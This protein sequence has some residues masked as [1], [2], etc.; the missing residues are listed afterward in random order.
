VRITSDELADLPLAAAWC[1]E[2]GAMV[3][4][5]PEW[6]GAGVDTVQYRLGALRL[7]V[8]TDGHS[9][10]VAALCARVLDELDTTARSAP[11]EAELMRR[12]LRAGLHLVMGRPDLTERSAVEVLAAVRAAAGEENVEVV[13]GSA[14]SSAV[15]GGD[16]VA[17]ALKQLATNAGK[18]DAA[19]DL[20][21]EESGPG[22]FRLRWRGTVA[23]GSVRTSRHPDRRGRWG[24]GLVR[25]AADALGATVVPVRYGENGHSEATFT[26]LSGAARFTLPLAAVDQR[27][28]IERAT[29]AWD[30]ETGLLPG[31]PVSA[32]LAELV[33]RAESNGSGMVTN[34]AFTARRGIANTWISLKP[35]STRDQA[36]DLIAGVAHENALLGNGAHALRVEGC[37]QVLGLILGA[38]T[39][40]WLRPALDEH[41]AA[42]CAAF[43]APA[44]TLRGI[45]RDAPPAPMAAFLASE[46]GGGELA[47]SNRRWTYRPARWSPL[48]LRLATGSA[49]T[50][51]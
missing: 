37:V 18:H 42:A 29:R 27:R 2:D 22:I 23:S 39:E 44:P 4:S 31:Q 45:G 17:L 7:I 24:L 41:L 36:R 46:G 9:A 19:T 32:D 28:R 20:T 38:S 25:L 43:G 33:G 15:R 5:T 47:E 16:T 49:V 30:E 8:A 50:I 12:S 1:R 10:E 6:T 34:E 21:A 40:M 13:L 11:P 3:A 51:S 48:L 26:L 14:V 35:R